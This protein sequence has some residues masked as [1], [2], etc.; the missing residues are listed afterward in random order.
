MYNVDTIFLVA[1]TSSEE[2]IKLAVNNS[3]GFVYL[4]MVKGITGARKGTAGNYRELI[5]KVKSFSNL[6]V[7]VGFGISTPQQARELSKTADG[8]IVGSAIVELVGKKQFKKA[9]ALVAGF[10]RALNVK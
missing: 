6:P 5:Q 4:I 10:R 7:A 3:K 9:L 8:V 1:P 2:R